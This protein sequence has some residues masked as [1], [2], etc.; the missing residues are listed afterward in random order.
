MARRADGLHSRVVVVNLDEDCSPEAFRELVDEFAD[1][2]EPELE[3]LGAA[4]VLAA[5]RAESEY[6]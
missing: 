4:S 2:P 5:M 1:G 6:A 3:S